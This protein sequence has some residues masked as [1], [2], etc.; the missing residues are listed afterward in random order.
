MAPAAVKSFS[1]LA[2]HGPGLPAPTGI[3]LGG[4]RGILAADI[5]QHVTYWQNLIAS[6]PMWDS[7]G[8]ILYIDQFLGNEDRFEGMKIQ[9][10]FIEPATYKAVA[11]DNDTMAADYIST[12]TEIDAV[13][14]VNNPKTNIYNLSPT[15]YIREIIAGG[16]VYGSPAL[17]A[18]AMAT[19]DQISGR[20]G[21][22]GAKID[23]TVT[24]FLT[25]LQQGV[26]NGNTPN[27]TAANQVL[28]SV[29]ANTGNALTK[30]QQ[31]MKVGAFAAR[32]SLQGLFHTKL[33]GKSEF[34]SLF[35]RQVKNYDKGYDKKSEVMYNY[36]ALEIR[37]A[38]LEL[39]GGGKDHNTALGA[40]QNQYSKPVDSMRRKAQ[41]ELTL[42]PATFATNE[43]LVKIK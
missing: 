27:E 4:A 17:Q 38:Y 20:S 18:R 6:Q 32:H 1:D 25:T 30:A 42:D 41:T 28:T 9:N 22:L 13:S 24:L 39:R 19:L 2:V 14:N 11:L 8:R 10:V 29:L 40:V 35:T 26:A 33:K 12:I 34:K 3:L 7:F 31:E 43:R 16:F 21:Q 37:F 5:A 15:D 36:L 23:Q